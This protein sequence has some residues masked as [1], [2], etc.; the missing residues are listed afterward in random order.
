MSTVSTSEEQTENT[1]PQKPS[2][3]VADL[4]TIA[5]IIQLATSR[6]AWKTEELSTVGLTYDKLLAFLE[7]AGAVSRVDA[8]E[9]G[10]VQTEEIA[11]A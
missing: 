8:S 5:K 10:A 1:E 4:V 11:N 3:G 9:T 2:L 6:G 7:A